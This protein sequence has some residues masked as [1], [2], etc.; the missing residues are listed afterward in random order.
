MVIDKLDIVYGQDFNEVDEDGEKKQVPIEGTGTIEH[1]HIKRLKWRRRS[2][3]YA[4]L[5]NAAGTT[6]F[7]KAPIEAQ[8]QFVSDIICESICDTEG[9]ATIKPDDLDDL[10]VWT[11][12]RRNA[13]F[14]AVA[15]YQSPTLE[16]SAKNSSSTTSATS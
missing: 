8:M 2:I 3:M 14:V 1:V 10:D 11:D 13:Y 16:N 6:E 15:K 5:R 12:M 4:A 9:K 7:D